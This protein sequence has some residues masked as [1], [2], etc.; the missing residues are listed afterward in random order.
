[1]KLM[2]LFALSLSIFANTARE[3]LIHKRCARKHDI[4]I[5]F[6]LASHFLVEFK[7][8]EQAID[9]LS[10]N[11]NEAT[12]APN[13][14]E[15]FLTAIDGMNE[16]LTNNPDAINDETRLEELAEISKENCDE[17]HSNHPYNKDICKQGVT[18]AVDA[19]TL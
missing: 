3:G 16:V 7:N 1:M 10:C 13:T 14:E 6:G 9:L 2:I 19:A 17:E 15:P 11:I 4:E 12:T 8:V 5:P 18:F